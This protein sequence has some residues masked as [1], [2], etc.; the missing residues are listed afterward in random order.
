MLLFHGGTNDTTRGTPNRI[1]S[2]YRA[3]SRGG[4]SSSEGRE[5]PQLLVRRKTV[6]KQTET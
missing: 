4:S 3:Q 5:E 6:G 1:K 2:D